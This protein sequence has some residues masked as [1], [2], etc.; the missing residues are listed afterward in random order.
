MATQTSYLLNDDLDAR[1]ANGVE[2][3][4]FFD[5]TTGEKREIELGEANRKHFA[6]HLEK[7]Q[8]YID[9]SRVV[10]APKPAKAVKTGSKSDLTKVREWAQANGYKVGDR[11]RIKAEIMDA[12]NK[13][14]P[15][16]KTG[17]PVAVETVDNVETALVE[18][19]E[20]VEPRVATEDELQEMLLQMAVSGAEP[21]L[22]D[23]QLSE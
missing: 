19:T 1:I 11:G 7:L 13:A 16:D 20:V 3:V 10:E 14:N 4:T 5:P 8:K 22:A 17:A 15:V 12:Y 9:A 21:T 2:T 23:L 6:N 18:S